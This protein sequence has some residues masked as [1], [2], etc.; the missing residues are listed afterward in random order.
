MSGI[1]IARGLLPED[2]EPL[3]RWAN[4]GGEHFLHQ[5][6]G[7]MWSYPLTR[8]QV[9][10]G[11][12]NIWRILDGDTFVGILQRLRLRDR[13]AIVGRFLLDPDRRGQGIGAQALRQFCGVLFDSA[14][15][16]T[17]TL[18]VYLFNDQARRCYEKCGFRQIAVEE[19][20]KGWAFSRMELKREE[21]DGGAPCP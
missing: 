19:D 2:Y 9:D 3:L 10:A 1:T 11:G 13:N 4:S 20:W 17:V 15:V 12:E 8:A 6:S 5:F 16:D 18:N 14:E 21:Y 7:P